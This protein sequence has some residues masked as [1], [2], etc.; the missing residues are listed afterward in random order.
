MRESYPVDN[1][2]ELVKAVIVCCRCTLVIY[3]VDNAWGPVSETHLTLLVICLV[4]LY[5]SP[6]DLNSITLSHISP[7]IIHVTTYIR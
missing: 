2:W 5:V 7:S 3:L 4:Y 6:G 1:A